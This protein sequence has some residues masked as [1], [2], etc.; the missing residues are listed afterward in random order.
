MQRVVYF[1][2][3]LVELQTKRDLFKSLIQQTKFEM[4]CATRG[5]V[6]LHHLDNFVFVLAVHARVAR[7]DLEETGEGGW[8]EKVSR[9]TQ[10]DAAVCGRQGRGQRASLIKLSSV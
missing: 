4:I 6:V 2:I 9:V 3:L 10:Q 7:K 1:C 8:G 5:P